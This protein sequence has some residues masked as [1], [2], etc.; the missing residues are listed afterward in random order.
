LSKDRL[1]ILLT[2]LSPFRTDHDFKIQKLCQTFQTGDAQASFTGHQLRQLALINPGFLRNAIPGNSTLLNRESNFV[3]DFR[4]SC[5]PVPIIGSVQLSNLTDTWVIVKYQLLSGCRPFNLKDGNL[6]LIQCVC[7]QSLPTLCSA[8][9]GTCNFSRTLNVTDLDEGPTAIALTNAVNAI[10]ENSDTTATTKI[11][12]IVITD[13]ALG[14]N[15]VALSGADAAFFAVVNNSELRLNAGV[16]LDFETKSSYAVTLTTGSVN[17]NHTLNVNDG[18]D[19]IEPGD[20]SADGQVT[21][22]GGSDGGADGTAQGTIKNDDSATVYVQL[23]KSRYIRSNSADQTKLE[24]EVFS[25]ALSSYVTDQS[26]VQVNSRTGNS[27]DVG[28]VAM[29]ESYGFLVTVG[30]VGAETYDLSVWVNN[31]YA[32]EDIRAAFG[33]GATDSLTMSVL[34]IL[35]A[36]DA[37]S[38][39]ALTGS[40]YDAIGDGNSANG[41]ILRAIADSVYTDINTTGSI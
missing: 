1:A 21:I 35:K 31:P 32:E 36:T 8:S 16:V 28:L 41:Q 15:I 5:C 4:H 13:D 37:E 26:L 7:D 38:G 11:A 39:S 2:P 6:T 12:D 9:T 22:N 27:A 29:A 23:Y 33:L 34:G 40:L 18:N 14:T 24:L 17:T 20:S 25:L 30:G 3:E 19:P 10:D